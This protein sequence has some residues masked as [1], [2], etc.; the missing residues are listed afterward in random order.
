MK[1]EKHI[2][3][4]RLASLRCSELVQPFPGGRGVW[5]V[6]DPNNPSRE[7][8]MCGSEAAARENAKAISDV[9]VAAVWHGTECVALY[10]EG[11]A[12]R[13]C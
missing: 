13:P 7:D 6:G 2:E 3:N 11:R 9:R 1:T 10:F 4:G 5:S 12:Y 8:A